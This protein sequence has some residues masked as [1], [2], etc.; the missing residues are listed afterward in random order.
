MRG[1]EGRGYPCEFCGKVFK[2]EH[3][4]R[5]HESEHTGEYGFNCKVC[6]KGFNIKSRYEKHLEGHQ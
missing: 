4:K 3:S 5:Y 6:N 1:H 2:T